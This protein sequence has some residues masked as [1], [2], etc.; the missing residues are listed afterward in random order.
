MMAMLRVKGKRD[1]DIDRWMY[2]LRA[3]NSVLPDP[4]FRCTSIPRACS[5]RIDSR[6]LSWDPI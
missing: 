2:R 6:S 3:A 5:V 4:P 1:I